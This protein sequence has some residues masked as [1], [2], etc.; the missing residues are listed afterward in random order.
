L[1]LQTTRES[2]GNLWVAK[3]RTMLA[4]LGIVI[5]TASVIAMSNIG[6]IAEKHALDEFRSTS[7]DDIVIRIQTNE[8]TGTNKLTANNVARMATEIPSLISAVPV[9]PGGGQLVYKGHSELFAPVVASTE[10]LFALAKL[11]PGSGRLLSRFDKL[12]PFCV[13]GNQLTKSLS[14]IAPPKIGDRIKV[15]LESLTVIGIL[16]PIDNSPL[17]PFQ[18]STTIFV[19]LENAPRISNRPI[20]DKILARKESSASI[21]S[22]TLQVNKFFQKYYPGLPVKI[23]TASQMIKQ[24][25]QQM[26]TYSLMLGA[27]GSI[28]LIVGGVGVMNVMLVAVTERR[29]E[30]GIRMAIGA[31]RR[32]IEM[33]F[34]IESL[35]LSLVGGVIG[36]IVGVGS[37]AIYAAVLNWS[38][39]VSEYSI[40]LGVGVSVLVGVFFGLYPAIS[41]AR[42]NP[43]DAL[44]SE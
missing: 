37:S 32:D 30:I 7:I 5:G 31:R 44:R 22:V 1:I 34:L 41:A 3:Q 40:P 14:G 21:E 43:V 11:K 39:T 6:A 24:M 26:H 27:I 28:S 38:F 36:T 12:E 33:M 2:L 29:S 15:G 9:I 4:L 23:S 16:E 18:P 20:I 35:V 17:L 10:E 42:L 13:I 19:S 8:L 25:K